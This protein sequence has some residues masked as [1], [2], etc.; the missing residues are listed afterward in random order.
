MRKNPRNRYL[1]G[2]D[3]DCL[4]PV[5]HLFQ[6]FSYFGE[7][8]LKLYYYKYIWYMILIQFLKKTNHQLTMIRR[9]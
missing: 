9:Y 2:G 1:L 5:L 3:P 7:I 8:H 4:D 6:M